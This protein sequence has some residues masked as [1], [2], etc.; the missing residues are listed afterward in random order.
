MKSPQ[1]FQRAASQIGYTFN[2]FYVDNKHFAYFNSGNNPVAPQ[3]HRRPAADA[4][5][6]RVEGLRPG[7]VVGAVHAVLPASAA[8]RRP[9]LHHELEQQAG[10][11]LR[12]ARTQPV[13]L[14]LPLAAARPADRQ[15]AGRRAQARRCPRSSTRWRRPERPTCARRRTCRWRWR[16][17]A[18]A[19]RAAR[20]ADALAKLRAWLASGGQRRDR[21][22][23]K[24]YDHADAVRILDAWW[25]L[26]LKAEFQPRLGKAL[27][28]R[29]PALYMFSNDPNN[30]GDHLGSAWQDGWYGYVVQG[31]ADAARAQAQRPLRAALLRQ[32]RP[33]GAAG[34]ARSLARRSRC[35]P[36]RST[37]ATPRAPPATSGAGTRALPAARRATQ[38]LIPWINR[39]DLPAGRRGAVAPLAGGLEAPGAAAWRGAGR[40]SRLMPVVASAV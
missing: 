23:D 24:V 18:R 6:V 26:W 36:R 4:G 21:D 32:R 37:P 9:A 13:Q 19:R 38:P 33:R 35:P 34:A 7:D 39:P 17:S 11:R 28:D 29:S 22:N 20:L 5:E 31:P 12:A 10:P 14:G 16:S 30:H 2:W 1:D 15:A 3:G 25:P 8:D 27:F 40:T